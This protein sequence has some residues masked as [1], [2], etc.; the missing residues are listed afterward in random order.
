LREKEFF[1]RMENLTDRIK[2]DA[3]AVAVLELLASGDREVFERNREDLE[4]I[5]MKQ[6]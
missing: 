6:K 2:N 3:L 5:R 4:R 1:S